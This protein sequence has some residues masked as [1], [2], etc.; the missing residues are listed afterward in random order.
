[1]II[2]W[3]KWLNINWPKYFV[4]VS[5]LPSS[6]PSIMLLGCL[7]AFDNLQFK[8]AYS[9][10]SPQ[11]RKLLRELASKS[12]QTS[13][14]SSS[15]SYTHIL[16][17]CA[18]AVTYWGHYYLRRALAS[19]LDYHPTRLSPTHLT[20]C[21]SLLESIKCNTSLL[22]STLNRVNKL[23]QTRAQHTE[24]KLMFTAGRRNCCM[25]SMV[26]WGWD[27]W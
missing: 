11:I 20:K 2:I 21:V 7:A 9:G 27:C 19:W 22:W 12:S 16:D 8:C 4:A 14:A 23:Y 15:F 18:L 13:I 10:E 17:F 5:L 25:I 26:A 6:P 3:Y 1:M 24:V